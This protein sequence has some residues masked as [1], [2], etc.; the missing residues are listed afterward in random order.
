VELKREFERLVQLHE[1]MN[2]EIQRYANMA[3]TTTAS[4]DNNDAVEPALPYD[5]RLLAFQRAPILDGTVRLGLKWAKCA[6]CNLNQPD[7]KMEKGQCHGACICCGVRTPHKRCVAHD[8]RIH[9]AA[10]KK[11]HQQDSN[12]SMVTTSRTSTRKSPRLHIE[13]DDEVQEVPTP[14][15]V[16]DLIDLTSEDGAAES[17]AHIGNLPVPVTS[18]ATAQR[19]GRPRLHQVKTRAEESGTERDDSERM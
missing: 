15:K 17:N 19:R 11:A 12:I 5:S 18:T 8:V 1:E 6:L 2:S 13:D 9:Q 4:G 16:I 3:T 10:L 7:Y 14:P